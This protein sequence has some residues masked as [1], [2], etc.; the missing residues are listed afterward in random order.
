MRM[1]MNNKCMLI[2]Y[3]K[4]VDDIV[5]GKLVEVVYDNQSVLEHTIY[6]Q[7]PTLGTC[8]SVMLH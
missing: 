3:A 1:N 6:L 2:T 4:V 5:I 7:I 8:T